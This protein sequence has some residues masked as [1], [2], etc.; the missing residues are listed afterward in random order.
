[1]NKTAQ[2]SLRVLRN[3]ADRANDD[4]IT[5]DELMAICHYSKL[6]YEII[7]S[8]RLGYSPALLEQSNAPNSPGIAHGGKNGV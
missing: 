7:R 3:L 8:E 5:L 1:M 4:Q 6:H 2:N